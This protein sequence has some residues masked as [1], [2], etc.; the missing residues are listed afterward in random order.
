MWIFK[1]FMNALVW[2]GR[3]GTRALAAFVFIGI[4]IPWVGAVLKPFVTE[5]VF[6]LLCVAFL[7]MDTVAFR[8]Y[9]RKPAIVLTATAWTSAF[10]PLLFGLVSVAIGLPARAPELH[11]ALMLQAIASP[12]V[13][14]PALA[15]LMG[16]D[17]TLVLAALLTSTALIPFT[18]PVFAMIFI[19]PELSLSPLAL[20]AKL[21]AILGGAALVGFAGRR[22]FGMATVSRNNEAID[23]VNMIAFFVFLAGIMEGVGLRFFTTPVFTMTL[24]A[25]AFLVFG[26][27]FFLTA[28]LFGSAGRKKA[29]ALGFMV[30]QRNMGLMLAATGGLLPDLTWLYFALAQFPIYLSPYLFTRLRSGP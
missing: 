24:L 14:S 18:A 28:L 1:A 4:A 3:Q 16:L 30:S 19:G 27:L 10:I 7:R 6:V 9:L 20:G 11:L 15:A 12:M 5:A 25:L 22:I 13:A 23:G 29:P 2:S 26:A 17:A 21:L 8:S